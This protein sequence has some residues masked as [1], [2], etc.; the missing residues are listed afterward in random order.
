MIH[1]TV[2]WTSVRTKLKGFVRKQVKDE[3][4]ADDIVQDV[5]LKVQHN[6]SQLQSSEKIIGWIYRIAKN[7]VI[8][9]FRKR[10]KVVTPSDLDWESEPKPLN[11]CVTG[12][13]QETMLTLPVKYREAL[14]LAELEDVSQTE[15]AERLKISYSGAK[16][17][18]QRARQMLKERMDE[19]YRIEMDKYGNVVVCENRISSCC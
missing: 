8:D 1:E 11:E 3:A 7:T 19:Q 2:D 4:V 13:L 15:L 9:H 10:S 18:V 16:S 17:R 5:Y 12:C 6:I 14:R